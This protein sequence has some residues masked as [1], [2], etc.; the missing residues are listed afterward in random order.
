MYNKVETYSALFT[1]CIVVSHLVLIY[2]RSLEVVLPQ[3][4][5]P[6]TTLLQARVGHPQEQKRPGGLVTLLILILE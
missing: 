4:K 1:I 2:R 6:E 3:V 5:G